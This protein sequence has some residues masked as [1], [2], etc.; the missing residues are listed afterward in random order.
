MEL[1]TKAPN[2]LLLSFWLATSCY[3]Q[4]L[5]QMAHEQPVLCHDNPVEQREEQ[6]AVIFTGTVRA[7]YQDDNHV[8]LSRAEVEIK[9]IL[10]GE[11]IVANLPEVPWLRARTDSTASGR[12]VVLVSGIGDK[13]ICHSQARLYDSRIFLLNKNAKGELTL[14]SSLIRLTLSNIDQ[15]DAIVR[16]I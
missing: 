1:S 3:S 13:R 2:V 6:A 16:G 10:K 4:R 7:L 11:K 12:R 9:R 15:A 5:Q 14:N 8:G